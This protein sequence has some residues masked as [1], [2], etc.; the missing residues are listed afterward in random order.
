MI[1]KNVL[2]L[3]AP[4]ELT[5]TRIQV[6]EG[7][8][9]GLDLS[10]HHALNVV[11]G[12]RGSGK[13]SIIELIRYCLDVPS[14]VQ[15]PVSVTSR[16]ALQVLGNGS[17]SVVIR[18]GDEDQVI[19]R[20]GNEAPRGLTTSL[21]P[22]II[23][24]NE[25][26][27]IGVEP[28]GRMALIDSFLAETQQ[29]RSAPDIRAA[30]NSE[31]DLLAE[32]RT[33]ADRTSFILSAEPE[34]DKQ[35]AEH[36]VQQAEL[37]RKAPELES[38]R[39][40]LQLL[41]TKHAQLAEEKHELERLQDV[42]HR[43]SDA[44]RSIVMA[45]AAQSDSPR[46][47]R[48]LASINLSKTFTANS[49][50]A[51]QSADR[52]L[53]V[54]RI[55]IDDTMSE[56]LAAARPIRQ[57]LN[58]HVSGLGT[59]STQV[60]KL[61]EQKRLIDVAKQRLQVLQTEIAASTARLDQRLD[62]FE[63]DA[64]DRFK[65]REAVINQLNKLLGSRIKITITRSG[66][67]APYEAEIAS[68][69]RGT[70]IHRSSVA[71]IAKRLSPRELYKLAS[72]GNVEQLCQAAGIAR[73]RGTRIMEGLR[74]SEFSRL[75]FFDV[76]DEVTF[77]LLVGT[78]YRPTEYLSTGQRCTA[79]LPILLA[80]PRVSLIFDQPEDHLDNAFIVETLVQGIRRRKQTGQVIVA[81]HNANVPVLGEA[82]QVILLQSDGEHGYVALSDDLDSPPVVEA[83][84]AVLEGGKDAF[85]RRAAFYKTHASN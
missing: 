13:T 6:S 51:L 12:S 78:D 18:Q 27:R 7:F 68:L 16:Q 47:A 17:V 70:G 52:D 49:L 69:M 1:S 8:L 55:D 64:A 30:I 19:T 66:S 23:G 58:E 84:L 85:A 24:T 3:D 44:L 54:A 82:E 32:L 26:E 75:L 61:R 38:D 4:A 76:D 5:I 46:F 59:I 15:R 80:Q 83:I 79:V 73:D 22:I 34:I 57:R 74:S 28:S 11:I 9:D 56:T 31:I 42:I 36:V 71:L 35:L 10:F 77:W 53:E 45:P 29:L 40:A 67:V 20:Q 62:A 63:T 25:I 43:Q 50:E 60:D 81:S 41:A 21:R 72:T 33:E 14:I 48:A 39:L 37:Q 65:R 2:E